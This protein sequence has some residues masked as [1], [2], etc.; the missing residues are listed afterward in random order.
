MQ[1]ASLTFGYRKR[2][3]VSASRPL[4]CETRN[5]WRPPRHARA[6][7][8]ASRREARTAHAKQSRAKMERVDVYFGGDGDERRRH[9]ALQ[10][11]KRRR[12]GR[13]HRSRRPAPQ[14]PSSSGSKMPVTPPTVLVPV[15][16][17]D[18][19]FAGGRIIG[20]DALAI[21]RHLRGQQ[22]VCRLSAVADHDRPGLQHLGEIGAAG[23]SGNPPV[24]ATLFPLPS[25]NVTCR[26]AVCSPDSRLAD[27]AW[28]AFQNVSIM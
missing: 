10:A 27:A 2:S 21:R 23:R 25:E 8:N 26:P 16:Y 17:E 3:C 5:P 24:G 4:A 14:I 6:I 9:E 12:S 11:D 1:K 7:R 19:L 13:S 28:R 20:H 18:D 22:P 15:S